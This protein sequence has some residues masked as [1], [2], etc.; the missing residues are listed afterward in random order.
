MIGSSPFCAAECDT[1]I[2]QRLQR[3]LSY[4]TSELNLWQF[5][6]LCWQKQETEAS[7][8][9]LELSKANGYTVG[10]IY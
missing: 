4:A 7:Q 3:F 9:Y 1:A 2:L 10:S 8:C 6:T 5:N